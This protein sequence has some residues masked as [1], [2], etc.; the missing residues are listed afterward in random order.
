MRYEL[1]S[2]AFSGYRV[3]QMCPFNKLEQTVSVNTVIPSNKILS[4]KPSTLKLV[5]TFT[6]KPSTLDW[7]YVLWISGCAMLQCA[8]WY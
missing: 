8:R 6:K 7:R 1:V 4:N 2:A 5:C 3:M